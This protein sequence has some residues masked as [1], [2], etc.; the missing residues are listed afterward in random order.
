[1]KKTLTFLILLTVGLTWAGAQDATTT[2]QVAPSDQVIYPDASQIL[3]KTEPVVEKKPAIK[4]P[5]P[6]V[7]GPV[8]GTPGTD[9][10]PLPSVKPILAATPV[11]ARKQAPSAAKPTGAVHGWFL[12]WTVTGNE[13]GVRAWATAVGPDPQLTALGTDLWEVVSGPVSADGLKKA[14][15]GQ[16]GK[17]QLVRR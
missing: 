7:A 13:A 12:R 1:M 4:E 10:A 15:E 2:V 6:A 9:T 5:V 16:A 17:A 14:L 8:E 3:N 11:P